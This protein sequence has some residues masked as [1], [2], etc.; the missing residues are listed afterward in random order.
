MVTAAL[1]LVDL[2]FRRGRF[3]LQDATDTATYFAWFALSLA[4][5]SAQALYARAFY[6]SGDTLTPM[7]ASTLIVIASLPVYTAMFHR[8]SYTG[9]AMASDL[10]ILLHTVVIAWLLDRK[11]LVPL[12]GLPWMEVMKAL[13]T[14]LIAAMLCYEVSIKFQMRGEWRG[15]VLALAAIGGT[16]LA[17]IAIGLWLMRSTLWRELRRKREA[18]MAEPSA[19]VERTEGG[20]QP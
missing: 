5:W 14:A 1:P 12:D 17:A 4:L 19:I 2:A 16:W 20:V 15:D 18:P 13:A 10:G 3:T 11:K 6:A 8:F 7:V 9:L